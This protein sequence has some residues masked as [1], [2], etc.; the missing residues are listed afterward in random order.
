[1]TKREDESD[2]RNPEWKWVT[3]AGTENPFPGR[4]QRVHVWLTL[5][6]VWGGERRI[7][8]FDPET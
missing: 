5:I 4:K 2:R 1:M 3:A 6:I 7:Q 8:G